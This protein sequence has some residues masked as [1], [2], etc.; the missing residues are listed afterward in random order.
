MKIDIGNWICS[1]KLPLGNLLL[2]Q[3]LLEYI[4]CSGMS[5]DDVY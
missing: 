3:G 5:R 1:L 2:L 4:D